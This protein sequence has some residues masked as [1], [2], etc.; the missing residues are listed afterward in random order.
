LVSCPLEHHPIA[1][2][3]HAALR[4]DEA[5]LE[6][7][8]ARKTLADVHWE[9]ATLQATLAANKRTLLRQLRLRWGPLP[10]EVE[11]V[12]ETTEDAKQL[13]EW[14]HR[15]ATAPSLKAVG[16]LPIS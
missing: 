9:Q 1:A 4:D 5:K 14:L 11:Q 6:V 8:M 2:E 7:D 13:E 3:G 12:I 10:T 16:I 15:F